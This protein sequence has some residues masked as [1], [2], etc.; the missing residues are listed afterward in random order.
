MLSTSRHA[1]RHNLVLAMKHHITNFDDFATFLQTTSIAY[2]LWEWAYGMQYDQQTAE[3]TSQLVEYQL[4]TTKM[5]EAGKLRDQ[6]FRAFG[7]F[8]AKSLEG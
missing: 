1:V 7:R 4:E 3:W 6:L 8:R 5:L 2:S